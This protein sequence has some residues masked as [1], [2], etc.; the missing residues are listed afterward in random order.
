M[1]RFTH[2]QT[3]TVSS[4]SNLYMYERYVHD[5]THL[6]RP[7]VAGGK[8]GADADSGCG[9]IAVAATTSA[10]LA[11]VAT[12]VTHG[13]TLGANSH[14][15][16]TSSGT[17]APTASSAT[18]VYSTA[19]GI[20]VSN[21]GVILGGAGLASASGNGGAGGAG[22]SLATGRVLNTG[23]ISGGAGGGAGGATGSGGAGGI[24]LSLGDG[25]AMNSG[26]I[27]GG[28]SGYT[29]VLYQN[30]TSGGAGVSIA[31]GSLTNAAGGTI[32]GGAGGVGGEYGHWG[33]G[34]VGVDLSGGVL[35]NAGT[36]TGGEGS[37]AVGFHYGGLGGAGVYL[38][39]GTVINTGAIIGGTGGDG[40]YAGIGGAGVFLNG[41]TLI[42]A[43]TIAGGDGGYDVT[44]YRFAASGYAIQFGSLAGTL[45][46]DPGAVF[47]VD[48]HA[49]LYP[50]GVVA[51]NSAAN[52]VLELSGTSSGTLSGLGHYFRGFATLVED[53]GASWTLAGTDTFAGAATINGLLD[54][55][56]T[57][58]VL[59]TLDVTGL[60]GFGRLIGVSTLAAVGSALVLE[61]FQPTSE[62]FVSGV[63]IVLGS[64]TSTFT[65][66]FSNATPRYA[67]TTTGGSTTIVQIAPTIVSGLATNSYTLSAADPGLTVTSTGTIRTFDTVA[68]LG[69]VRS[70]SVVISGNITAFNASCVSLR[71]G[72][73]MNS[74]FIEAYD[75]AR[76]GVIM[77][78]GS[79]ENS[80]T[81][82]CR[83]QGVEPIW[84]S[85]VGVGVRL[86]FGEITNS[87][88][89]FGGY[90]ADN[91]AVAVWLHNSTLIN[92]GNVVGGPGGLGVPAGA[93]GT[94]VLLSG[95]VVQ[96]HGSIS[97]G[98]GSYPNYRG[99]GGSGRGGTGIVVLSGVVMNAGQVT[100]GQGGTVMK[101][102]E[103]GHGHGG[104]GISLRAGS[105]LNDFRASIVGGS[106]GYAGIY[107]GGRGGAGVA[108]T[109]GILTNAGRVIGGAG[110]YVY[111][112]TFAVSGGVGGVGIVMS[113]GTVSNT[114][115]IA[116]G[117]G[118]AVSH[119]DRAGV[120]GAGGVG[121]F[122]QGGVLTNAGTIA[123]GMGGFGN[124]HDGAA[125][126]AVRF[127]SAAATLVVDP[128]AVFEGRV[129]G[130]GTND[131][132]VLGS[133]AAAGT[134]SGLGTQFT[135]FA[136]IAVAAGSDW[137][138]SGE[139]RTGPA[140]VLINA[141]NLLATTGSFVV[142]GAVENDGTMAVSAGATLEVATQEVSGTGTF[143]LS[144]A[145]G[146]LALYRGAAASE[147]VRFTGAA[148][149][150][151]LGAP[152]TFGATITG[153]EHG[154][155][156]DLVKAQAT[157][158]DLAN[159]Q[160][161]V[162]NGT[163]LVAA[164]TF[165]DLA[166][167]HFGF[168]SDGHGGTLLTVA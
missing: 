157:S 167:S 84:A 91:G 134:L 105:V 47:A 114:G 76:V 166:N 15:T 161:T 164:L 62:T 52:D 100:G 17:I 5:A 67:L 97:G 34:G 95:G 72:T 119:V 31:S 25:S 30:G 40:F 68:V 1:N 29:S 82:S 129:V 44:S 144:S 115:L 136:Q 61:N 75:S 122:M 53:A 35:T 93:G 165:S 135:G 85:A 51:A 152:L 123:G 141:G 151:V 23:S 138:I 79:V 32:V 41:G 153:F 162:L 94:G 74:G 46:I 18:A 110:G 14:L 118:G 113:G 60:G 168:A 155:T 2:S 117:V 86:S 33:A 112:F 101:V 73:L 125:G 6:L 54:V 24:G 71:N 146:T 49:T 163:R 160:L 55:T 133:A 56:G 65:V 78:H 89:V 128:G 48:Y 50:G 111:G 130:N 127:G 159:N 12:L 145:G 116:G 92:S 148:G 120:G 57:L 143:D 103:N 59:G 131:T 137:S 21:A 140:T 3:S 147:T 19:G 8:A 70:G 108:I 16:V 45:I 124:G 126:D 22:V 90:G 98:H 77:S 42:N 149:V 69:S 10:P 106:G 121:V 64:G 26:H 142:S 154:D 37:G 87:G 43:G 20:Q 107:D 83:W 88:Q 109:G 99:Y 66:A 139:N 80:G 39:G 27:S 81:I 9:R 7:D 13:Y 58:D 132:M 63:G 4:Y 104:D 156:V 38:H 96:N 102:G 28:A 150:L 158:L 36:I 11:A